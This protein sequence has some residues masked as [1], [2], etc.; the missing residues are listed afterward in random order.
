[1]NGPVIDGAAVLDPRRRVKDVLLVDAVEQMN[2]AVAGGDDRVREDPPVA[3]A[4]VGLGAH[5]GGG[6][7]A[8][9]PEQP[10][11]AVGELARLGV[12]S[13]ATERVVPKRDV[14]R[15]RTR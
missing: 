2:D 5:E 14:A 3:A 12:I 8:G 13:V 7:L 9:A 10:A 15:I 11:E 1:L 4:P 6:H